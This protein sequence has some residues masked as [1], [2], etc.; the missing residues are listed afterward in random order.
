ML[1]PTSF[2]YHHTSIVLCQTS[3]GDQLQGFDFMQVVEAAYSEADKLFTIARTH[4]HAVYCAYI[5]GLKGNWLYLAQ[6]TPN[7]GDLLRPT[8]SEAKI[9]LTSHWQTTPRW[10]W[11]RD[12]VNTSQAWRPCH[13]QPNGDCWRRASDVTPD[14]SWSSVCY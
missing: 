5:N 3:H 7:I 13:H 2:H 6:T 12:H 9:Y 4:P 8:H 10:P 14:D 1:Q 11:K